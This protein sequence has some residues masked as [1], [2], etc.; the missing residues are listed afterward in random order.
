MTKVIGIAG[1]IGAGKDAVAKILASKGA[2]IIEAD[3]V[4]HSL[5]LPESQISK[6]VIKTFGNT[7]KNKDG[8]INRKKLAKIVFADRK[9]LIK[10]NEITHPAIFEIISNQVA[11]EKQKRVKL[12]VINAALLFEIGFD[13]VVDEIWLIEAPTELRIARLIKKGYTKK[14][15]AARIVSQGSFEHFVPHAN[16]LIVNDGSLAS[17]KKKVLKAL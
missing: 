2:I 10:L 7:I 3:K 4:G 15:A 17:L 8:S 16:Q 6:K 5:L 1:P 13:L 14:D 9:K 12:V 11:F